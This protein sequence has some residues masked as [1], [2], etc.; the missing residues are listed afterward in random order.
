MQTSDFVT[1]L[2]LAKAFDLFDRDGSGEISKE[3]LTEIMTELGIKLSSSELD[4]IVQMIDT[5]G[6]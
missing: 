2:D 3:E 4:D 1:I 6:E 5:S